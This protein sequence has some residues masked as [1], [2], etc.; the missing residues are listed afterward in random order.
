MFCCLHKV[1]FTSAKPR[2]TLV[3]LIFAMKFSAAEED[4]LFTK[5]IYRDDKGGSDTV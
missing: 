4:Y 2:A 1:L 5:V 3:N